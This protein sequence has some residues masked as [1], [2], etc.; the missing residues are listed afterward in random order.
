MYLEARLEISEHGFNLIGTLS[1]FAEARLS[2]DRHSCIVG[3]LLKRLSKIAQR[4]FPDS[5]L[6]GKTGNCP[7]ADFDPCEKLFSSHVP[8]SL[9]WQ[10]LL[11][12]PASVLKFWWRQ[13]SSSNLH[14][15]V[16]DVE[17]ELLNVGVVVEV[18]FPDKAV[19]L[20]LAIGGGSSGGFDHGRRLHVGQLLDASLALNDV[21]DLQG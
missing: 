5:S 7:F 9:I 2:N 13:N 1:V 12:A 20:S 4:V 6:R 10:C 16:A 19:D 18:G 21:A 17:A 15:T 8:D 3:N 14:Q 11:F